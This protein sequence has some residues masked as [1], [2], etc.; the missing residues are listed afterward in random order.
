LQRL[1]GIATLTRRYVEA[2]RQT[3][4]KILDT[5]KTTPGLRLLERYAVR[6]GGGVNHRFDLAE[7]AMVKDNHWR[8]AGSLKQALHRLRRSAGRKKIIVEAENL[9]ELQEALE[10]KAEWVLLDNMNLKE[11]RAAVNLV[12]GRCRLEASGGVTLQNV[13]AIARCGVDFISVGALTH[14]AAAVDLSLELIG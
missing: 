13:R 8:V 2:V 7:A 4:V 1:S 12:R 5:R 11:L 9:Q 3:R 6:I 14:S 10:A